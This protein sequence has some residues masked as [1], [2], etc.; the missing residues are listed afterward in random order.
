MIEWSFSFFGKNG[1]GLGLAEIVTILHNHSFSIFILCL[2]SFNG[3]H[4]CQS[5]ISEIS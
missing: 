5:R 4:D 2:K 1:L 3:S